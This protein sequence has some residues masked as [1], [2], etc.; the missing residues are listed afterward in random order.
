L[1][2]QAGRGEL[3]TRQIL[4]G[5]CGRSTRFAPWFFRKLAFGVAFAQTPVVIT[6]Q[7]LA[8][9][10]AASTPTGAADAQQ[11]VAGLAQLFAALLAS[12]TLADA[13][14]PHH[15]TEVLQ[16]YGAEE[17]GD[18]AVDAEETRA[19]VRDTSGERTEPRTVDPAGEALDRSSV[20]HNPVPTRP[21]G[22]L[23]NAEIPIAASEPSTEAGRETR[24]S[25]ALVVGDETPEGRA[26]PVPAARPSAPASREAGQIAPATAGAR[27]TRGVAKPVFSTAMTLAPVEAAR[28]TAD[29]AESL[30]SGQP[31]AAAELGAQRRAPEGSADDSG[32]VDIHDADDPRGT[33]PL[34]TTSSAAP[35]DPAPQRSPRPSPKSDS[36]VEQP[37]DD[38]RDAGT[39]DEGPGTSPIARPL[40]QPSMLEPPPEPRPAPQPGPE[41]SPFAP[42]PYA[43]PAHSV[44]APQTEHGGARSPQ[45]APESSSGSSSLPPSSAAELSDAFGGADAVPA[46]AKKGRPGLSAAPESP[47][48]GNASLPQALHDAGRLQL[49]L[50]RNPVPSPLIHKISTVFPQDGTGAPRN[51]PLSDDE[52]GANA[53]LTLAAAGREHAL[54]PRR[55]SLEAASHGKPAAAPSPLRNGGRGAPMEAPQDQSSEAGGHNPDPDPG[56]E[57]GPSDRK[58]KLAAAGSREFATVGS[59]QQAPG[60]DQMHVN[61]TSPRAGAAAALDRNGTLDQSAAKVDPRMELVVESRE[62]SAPIAGLSGAHLALRAA[63]PASPAQPPSDAQAAA[64]RRVEAMLDSRPSEPSRLQLVVHDDQLGRVSV[65]LVERAGLVDAML[66]AD[67]P[68][69]AK[70]LSDSLLHLTD[71]LARGRTSADLEDARMEPGRSDAGRNESGRDDARRDEAGRR[72]SE[73]RREQRRRARQEAALAAA[74]AIFSTNPISQGA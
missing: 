16:S 44:A 67:Q 50:G 48:P 62:I 68:Q 56:R 27:R 13:H 74:G 22:R 61:E 69:T 42:T 52:G 26:A 54:R 70:Q 71:A 17:D 41:P 64:F 30:P 18:P 59:Q 9:T 36:A 66:R 43:H 7:R 40:Q 8:N 25:V 49:E 19:V 12:A 4:V 46:A 39:P 55:M 65:R 60:G 53:A 31:A 34:G 21:A 1:T 14:N 33:P 15:P 57:H 73:R 58:F 45:G 37:S 38:Q 3:V 10:E 47:A 29:R 2:G 24:D 5:P 51:E 20:E 72:D 32:H 11:G 23:L 35:A 28:K 6:V 63:D